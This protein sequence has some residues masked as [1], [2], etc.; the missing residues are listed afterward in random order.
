MKLLHLDSSALGAHSVSRQLSAEI[1]SQLTHTWPGL[2]VNYHDLA[3]HP[4]PHWTSGATESSTDLGD[5][6][7]AA[8]QEADVVVIGAPMYNFSI[9]SQLKAWV[10]RILVAGKTFR[11]TANG[12]EG[13]ASGKQVIIASARGGAYHGTALSVM[14]FHESYLRSVFEFIGIPAITFIRAEGLALGDEQKAAGIQSAR[15]AIAQLSTPLTVA[16]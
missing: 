9:P 5:Q 4:L 11:Y 6:T 2:T 13:L 3:A 10:D 8:F 15:R 7:M 12:A 16:A 14:D 1:V